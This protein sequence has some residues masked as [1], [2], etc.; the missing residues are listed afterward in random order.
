MFVAN[1]ATNPFYLITYHLKLQKV[2]QKLEF[3]ERF[4]NKENSAYQLHTTMIFSSQNLF[5][6]FGII[7]FK[8]VGS[9][10]PYTQ[11]L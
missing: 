3:S 11:G 9:M 7:S 5:V 2:I 10:K 6:G 1:V 4:S 8:K